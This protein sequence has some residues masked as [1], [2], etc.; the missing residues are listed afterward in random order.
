MDRCAAVLNVRGWD[1]IPNPWLG[2]SWSEASCRAVRLQGLVSRRGTSLSVWKK[3][4]SALDRSLIG[5]L[6]ISQFYLVAAL[7]N[8]SLIVNTYDLFAH[9][10]FSFNLE[11]DRSLSHPADHAFYFNSFLGNRLC[12]R[13]GRVLFSGFFFLYLVLFR[14]RRLLSDCRCSRFG[15][16]FN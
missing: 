15:L 8:V 16:F 10:T 9:F 6:E 5:L 7:F 11:G 1:F 13:L 4:R 2:M 14:W 12:L 3:K